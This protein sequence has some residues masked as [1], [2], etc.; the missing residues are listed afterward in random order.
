MGYFKPEFSQKKI[1][2]HDLQKRFLFTSFIMFDY[3][4]S[5]EVGFA[6]ASLYATTIAS[7]MI[8][9]ISP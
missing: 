8:L 4:S 1:F 2:L 5:P 6:K 9:R 3:S 7:S